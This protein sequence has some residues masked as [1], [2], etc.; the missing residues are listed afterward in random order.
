MAR[1]L[2]RQ[3]A[4]QDLLNDLDPDLP[5]PAKRGCNLVAFL[6]RDAEFF[7]DHPPFPRHRCDAFNDGCGVSFLQPEVSMGFEQVVQ[8]REPPIVPLVKMCSSCAGMGAVS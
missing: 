5:R 8:G 7:K 1:Y 6:L 2:R 4:S 3:P